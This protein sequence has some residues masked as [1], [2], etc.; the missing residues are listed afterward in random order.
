MPTLATVV[1]TGIPLWVS[2]IQDIAYLVAAILFIFGIKQLSSPRTARRGNMTAGVGMLLAI[3]ATLYIQNAMSVVWIISAMIIGSAVGAVLAIRIQMTAMP[4]LVAL[5]NGFG[6]LASV[7]VVGSEYLRRSN[8]TLLPITL[9]QGLTMGL[10]ILIGCVTFTGS[11]VAYGKLQ[12]VI[13]GRP[14]QWPGQ[15]IGNVLLFGIPFAASVWIGYDNTQGW[16]LLVIAVLSSILG[17]TL[18]IAIGGA[19]MPVM[20]ALLNSY[21][22]MAACATGFI[23]DPPN[24]ALI[25]SGALVGASGIILTS[26]M[27]KAM[28]RSLANVLFGGVG[29]DDS[30]GTAGTTHH[31]DR[32]VRTVDAEEL[33]MMLDG[34][35][36]II[37]VPGY[38]MAVAQA[39]H[40]VRD[41][42]HILEKAGTEVYF[43]IHPVAG[44][45]PGHMNVLLAEVDIP[46]DRL[47]DL[48]Q[49]NPEFETAEIAM[50]LGAN[51]VVN[52]AARH[53]KS[54]PI[55]G[56]PILNVDK[57]QTV[58]VCKRSLAAGYAGVENELFVAPNTLM[59][60]GD[61]KKTIT[62]LCKALTEQ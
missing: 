37:I 32:P 46:Y 40:A 48:E 49:C 7:L 33:A 12:G 16:L 28:N 25:V 59:F 23:L 31:D 39:Q 29:T 22:G 60:F 54:S 51:D 13:A 15:L 3:V 11:M 4:Q 62:E 21:S 19:D 5:F 43:G 52:P 35:R 44:R 9:D 10:S 58:I 41:L 8:D 20:V 30:S 18:T 17:V 47:L 36:K 26:I 53:D 34:V 50:V 1:T 14:R 6:G 45:M 38:G 2:L 27:C 56:M 55:Y 42:F 61:A 57:A 24:K